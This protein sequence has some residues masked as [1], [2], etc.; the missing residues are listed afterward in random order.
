MTGTLEWLAG[1]RRRR[2]A[3]AVAAAVATPAV[4]A[5]VAFWPASEARPRLLFGVNNNGVAHGVATPGQAAK[6]IAG[7][8]AEIDRVQIQWASFEPTPGDRRFAFYDAIYRADLR[9][10]V[11]PLFNLSSAPPWATDALCAFAP[12]PCHAAPSPEHYADAARTAAAIA[13]RYPRAAGIEI[14]NEPNAPYFW[15][16]TPDP[17]A[18]SRLLA[19]SYRAVKRV[20][21]RMPVVGG[22]TS[23][24]SPGPV[25]GHIDAPDFVSALRA[26]HALRH[27]DVLSLHA[28]AEQGDTSGQ[29]AVE[30]AE[31]VRAALGDRRKPIWIT[32]TGVTTTGSH[33]MSEQAQA[34]TLLRITELLPAI[35]SVKMV[36]IHTLVEPPRGLLSPETGF[37][38]VRPGL[39]PKPAYCALSASMGGDGASC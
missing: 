21:P 9:R 5:V 27:M 12:N 1:I 34:L 2:W 29:S 32:E 22:V 39:R 24:G 7:M 35:P 11:R 13:R 15:A 14:W 16:P 30:N 19:K 31:A 8:G 4:V 38:I 10:G 17:Y 25:P 36:L 33:A 28:Y 20:R 18:Y 6:L 23:S 3:I 37:G 26:Y